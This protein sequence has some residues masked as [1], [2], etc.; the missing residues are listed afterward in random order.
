[1]EVLQHSLD[2]EQQQL[3]ERL[4]PTKL[5]VPSG[6]NIKLMY[7]DNAQ[8]PVL[9]VRIQEVFGLAQTPRINDGKQ[10]VLMHLLSPGFKPVQITDDLESF[11]SNAYFEVK[12]ELRRRYPKHVWPDNPWEEPAI[13]GV[14]RRK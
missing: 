5:V 12:K 10:S 13:R 2:Y 11:W 7:R 9:A 8:A 6:F 4:A 14:K 3:L 1:V